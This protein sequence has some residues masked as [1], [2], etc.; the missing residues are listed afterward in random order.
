MKL[1]FILIFLIVGFLIYN[2]INSK[3][4]IRNTKYFDND[5]NYQYILDNKPCTT[6][7]CTGDKKIEDQL[8]LVAN[9]LDKNPIFMH[10]NLL[11][12]LNDDKLIV[13]NIEEKDL[14]Y[15]EIPTKVPINLSSMKLKVKL[16]YNGY[17]YVGLLNNNF[18]NQEYILYEKDY[19]QDK[20][21]EDKL[22]YYILVKIFQDKYKIMYELQP[23]KK[24]LPN[25]YIWA[26]YGSFQIGPLIF[27]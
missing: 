13:A 8:L 11:Y 6:Y 25:E 26:S 27:N 20:E 3:E 9:D 4:G 18:Y 14:S 12:K 23:R 1:T 15:F 21:L 19:D 2:S 22:Y 24:I 16:N 10:K 5:A 7:N 17:K